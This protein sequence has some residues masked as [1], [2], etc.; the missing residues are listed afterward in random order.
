MEKGSHKDYIVRRK[1][2]NSKIFWE[3]DKYWCY[4]IIHSAESM[5]TNDCMFRKAPKQLC[6]CVWLDP[7][8]I[9]IL[10]HDVIGEVFK[11][12]GTKLRYYTA[13]HN[14]TDKRAHVGP[15]NLTSIHFHVCAGLRRAQAHVLCQSDHLHRALKLWFTI[16]RI[17]TC[18]LL[19]AS[20]IYAWP[21]VN[22]GLFDKLLV[23]VNTW[24][25]PVLLFWSHGCLAAR[26]GAFRVL[27]TWLWV[28]L[29]HSL[30]YWPNLAKKLA[31]F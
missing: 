29:T 5:N 2:L 16:A 9:L 24:I 7:M 6:T 13:C 28:P 4:E 22:R 17:C 19:D 15:W 12:T 27:G 10:V 8:S 21:N 14:R 18:A 23:G 25:N 3:S 26:K 30:L 31:N 1:F 20:R 11:L